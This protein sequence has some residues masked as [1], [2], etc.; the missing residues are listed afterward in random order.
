MKFTSKIIVF[1]EYGILLG[2]Q[3]LAIPY[4]RYS[5]HLR[6]WKDSATPV[7]ETERISNG[8]LKKYFIF[9]KDEQHNIGFLNLARFAEELQTGLIFDSSIP[10]GY[11]LGSSGALTAAIYHRYIADPN[12]TDHY[13]L[14]NRLA[15]L[16]SYFHKVSSGID[17]LTSY[18]N[19]PVLFRNDRSVE[20]TPDLSAFFSAYSLF[21]IDIPSR[22]NTGKLVRKFIA[23]CEEPAY[24]KK[25]MEEYVP[26]VDQTIAAINSPDLK[27]LESYLAKYSQFQYANFSGMI[28]ETML[29]HLKYGIDS[30]DFYLKLCGSGG[31]GQMLAITRHRSET[32]NYLKL[33]RLNYALAEHQQTINPMYHL[34]LQ[35]HENAK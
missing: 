28:P 7:T 13:T 23:D 30:G 17:P 27:Q 25:M 26:L 10:S 21:L 5:G 22:G 34:N 35:H 32:E 19:Q 24:R 9:L 18:L 8:V 29:R 33:N 6:T 12:P 31:G 4:P 15:L 2:S 20:T 11:G 14:K 3:A 1:G 16:E